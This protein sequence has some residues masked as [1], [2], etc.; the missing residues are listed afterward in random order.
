MTLI[1]YVGPNRRPAWF[2]A[3]PAEL[4]RSVHGAAVIARPDPASVLGLGLIWGL[5]GGLGAAVVWSVR[6]GL[7]WPVVASA[8]APPSAAGP[9]AWLLPETPPEADPSGASPPDG[10]QEEAAPEDRPGNP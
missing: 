9:T 5:I 8:D 7:R 1:A 2:S 6:H 10:G 3:P 4:R